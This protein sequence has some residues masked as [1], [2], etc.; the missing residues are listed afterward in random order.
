MFHPSSRESLVLPGHLGGRVAGQGQRGEPRFRLRRDAEQGRG[1]QGHFRTERQ[2]PQGPSVDGQSPSRDSRDGSP[3]RDSDSPLRGQALH[4]R[5]KSDPKDVSQWSFS[6][7]QSRTDRPR[8]CPD[9]GWEARPRTGGGGRL[10]L[11]SWGVVGDTM[12]AAAAGTDREGTCTAGTCPRLADLIRTQR[13]DPPEGLSPFLFSGGDFRYNRS[14]VFPM[15]KA[16]QVIE[17][18]PPEI[19]K[20]Y[21]IG[22]GRARET[23][24]RRRE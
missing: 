23:R 4:G 11:Y 1:R 3:W 19:I 18:G 13:A 17:E 16:L 2:G 22:G 15:E 7:A 24:V 12:S 8:P 21:T 20:A 9:R 14:G 10:G 6:E 5:R